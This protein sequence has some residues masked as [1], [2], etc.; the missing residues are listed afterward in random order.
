MFKPPNN[1]RHTETSFTGWSLARFR[2]RPEGFNDGS[3]DREG[4][5]SVSG[6]RA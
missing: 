2:T 3:K 6:C 4:P 5:D 1:P